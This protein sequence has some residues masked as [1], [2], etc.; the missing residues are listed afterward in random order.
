MK[1]KRRISLIK[2][3]KRKITRKQN[4]IKTRRKKKKKSI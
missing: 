3:L 2:R 4:Q 1:I